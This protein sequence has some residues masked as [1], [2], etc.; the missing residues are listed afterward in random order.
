M[1][2]TTARPDTGLSA[3][4]DLPDQTFF[5]EHD[6]V[7]E[8]EEDYSDEEAGEDVF[9]FHR[10]VTAVAPGTLGQGVSDGDS[11][12]ETT[13]DSERAL[14]SPEA[15]GMG[16]GNLPAIP[17]PATDPM[18]ATVPTGNIDTTGHV[19]ALPYDPRAPPPFTG[20]SNLNNSSFAY[21]MSS[22]SGGRRRS[23]GPTIVTSSRPGT[24]VSFLS[25]FTPRSRG[26]TAGNSPSR[27]SFDTSVADAT[28][29]SE[30]DSPGTSKRQPGRRMRSSTPLIDGTDDGFSEYDVKSATTSASH[31][32]RP[33][34]GA[35]RA[36]Y[37]LSELDGSMTVP[38]GMTTR[39]DG[40]GGFTKHGSDGEDSIGIMDPDMIEEDSPYPEVRASVSNIDD[41]DMPGELS[42]V[43]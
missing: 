7:S 38:D 11:A 40:A 18:S 34:R 29:H 39:G 41:P 33:S 36:S 12:R 23:S 27:T 5:P 28:D 31:S 20:R 4:G 9:A 16:P 26:T 6:E 21:S 2:P 22:K 13:A 32:G 42:S 14:T 37:M 1:R 30:L 19:P 3:I 17:E 25:R 24:A 10:P 15:A 8:G 35:S 43:A